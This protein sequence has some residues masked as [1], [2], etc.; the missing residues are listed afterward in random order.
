MLR[1]TEQLI[2]L[3]SGPSSSLPKDRQGPSSPRTWVSRAVL[4]P[5]TAMGL[6]A[7]G[8]DEERDKLVLPIHL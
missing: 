5:D 3:S 1:V 4:F 8:E 7:D 6:Q 2:S